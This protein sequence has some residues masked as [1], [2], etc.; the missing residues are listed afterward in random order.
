MRFYYKR[1]NWEDWTQSCLRI[2]SVL[3][4]YDTVGDKQE[5][6]RQ[7]RG[8]RERE[9]EKE[10]SWGGM[11]FHFGVWMITDVSVWFKSYLALCKD[12]KVSKCFL[13]ISSE[14][15][16]GFTVTERLSAW[17]GG[18]QVMVSGSQSRGG[19]ALPP[20]LQQ[21]HK[22]TQGS[23]LAQATTRKAT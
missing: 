18:S 16:Q 11:K 17:Y 13:K 4:I 15:G 2:L 10:E 8:E 9:G 21:G 19:A 7:S 20:Y 6:L 3:T 22:H 5:M 12:F 1:R 23:I 14:S